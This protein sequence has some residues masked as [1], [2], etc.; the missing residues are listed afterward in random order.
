MRS[1]EMLSEFSSCHS[2]A[3]ICIVTLNAVASVA[4]SQSVLLPHCMPLSDA[5]MRRT[6]VFVRAVRRVMSCSHD[7]RLLGCFCRFFCMHTLP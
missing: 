6:E 4:V 2:L 3:C 5:Y 1:G 7:G